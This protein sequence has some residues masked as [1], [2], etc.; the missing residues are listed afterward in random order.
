MTGIGRPNLAGNNKIW[1]TGRPIGRPQ[2][3][4]PKF[5]YPPIGCPELVDQLKAELEAMGR[6]EWAVEDFA[7][8]PELVGDPSGRGGEVERER[9]ITDTR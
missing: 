8:L 7:R 4:R 3:G 2:F 6:W 1:S 9:H 5:G